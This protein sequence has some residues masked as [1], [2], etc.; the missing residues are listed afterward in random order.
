MEIALFVV[1]IIVGIIGWLTRTLAQTSYNK[2]NDMDKTVK[3]LSNNLYTVREDI[4][5]IKKDIEYLR[6]DVDK[7]II[8]VPGR[9]TK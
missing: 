9:F 8:N 4:V 5:G 6:K 3:V 1:T 2:I 7:N